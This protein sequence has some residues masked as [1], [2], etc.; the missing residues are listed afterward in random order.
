MERNDAMLSATAVEYLEIIYN[1]TV[2]GDAVVNAR[3]AE[4]FRVSPPSVTEMLHRL[5]RDGYLTV[6]RTTGARLTEKGVAVAEA[7]LRRHRLS[8]RFLMDV[9]KMDWIAAHEEA[10]ALQ[11]ALTP[12]IEAHM[13]SL[14]GNPTTCPHGNPIPGSAPS[15]YDFLRIH[16]AMRLSRA[17][18]G[19]PL[20]VLCISEVVEDET[21]LLRSVG[22]AGIR[23]DAD[24]VVRDLGSFD[25][26]RVT[27]DVGPR[28]VELDR[29]VAEKIWVYAHH[30]D[31]EMSAVAKD[32]ATY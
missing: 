27:V 5:E 29:A 24:L 17:A 20:R 18:V 2:E 28:T 10:H 7:S 31:S 19:T 26:D 1:I 16:R 14:L 32:D 13:V 21:T 3:L 9:L 22:E 6:E 12:A 4:K 8:E 23:P 30:S 11:N 15:T 25:T